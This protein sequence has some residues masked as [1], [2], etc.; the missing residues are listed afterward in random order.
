MA[1]FQQQQKALEDEAELCENKLT[2]A[3]QILKGLGGEEVRW[4][5]A[6]KNLR[7]SYGLLTGML[8]SMLVPGT[9]LNIL[10]LIKKIVGDMLV[11]AGI[12]AY[13]GPFT[14]I[15]RE[16]CVKNWVEKCI[17]MGLQCS[18]NY[19][20]CNVLGNP[21]SIQQWNLDGLP[22]DDF[23][24]ESAIIIKCVTFFC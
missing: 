12:I 7:A 5:Q 10:I 20:L 14:I 22:V 8:L 2:R 3:E 19:R 15:F 1:D 6:A 21:V 18:D 11:S 9:P 16:P 23:S 24:I 13:L 4:T 17:E